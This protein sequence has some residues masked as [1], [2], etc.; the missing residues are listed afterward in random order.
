MYIWLLLILILNQ[1]WQRAISICLAGQIIIFVMRAICVMCA[2]VVFLPTYFVK[3]WLLSV[4]RASRAALGFVCCMFVVVVDVVV[5]VGGFFSFFFFLLFFFCHCFLTVNRRTQT[6]IQST[7]DATSA[8]DHLFSHDLPGSR[9]ITDSFV[10][11]CCRIFFPVLRSRNFVILHLCASW[12]DR[13]TNAWLCE[14][15]CSWCLSYMPDSPP[16]HCVG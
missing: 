2:A 9:E 13:P 15:A 3:W 6:Y 1:L 4:A 14:R 11:L 10:F 8:A 12:L 5:V 16:A 7:R